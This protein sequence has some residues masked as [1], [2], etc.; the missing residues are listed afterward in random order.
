[1]QN[2]GKLDRYDRALLSLLQEEAL[3]TADELS[4]FVALSPSA[5]ARRVRR[6]RDQRVI[7]ADRA[8][9]TDRIG[10]FLT[11]MVEVQLAYHGIA[12]LEPL[13]QKLSAM[14][15]VQVIMDVAGSM[16]L[17]LIVAVRDLDAFNEFADV[18]LAGDPA[19]R[20]YETRLI[21]RRRKFTTAWPIESG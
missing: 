10:P 1:M 4:K 9:V 18:A 13:F 6:L 5:I 7:I 8:V 14:D 19:V 17:V 15:E 11:A 12:Q 3:L 21:K 16:D 20:R 2:I